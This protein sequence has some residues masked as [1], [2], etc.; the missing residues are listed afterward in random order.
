MP[1]LLQCFQELIMRNYP[2]GFYIRQPGIYLPERPF[3][4]FEFLGDG[5]LD[6][7]FRR[8]PR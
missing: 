4:V 2:S 7:G 6:Y 3:F 8:A 1:R 5:L